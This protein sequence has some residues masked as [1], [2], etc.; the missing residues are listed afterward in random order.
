MTRHEADGLLER[1][2]REAGFDDFGWHSLR[3]TFASH[4][5]MRGVQLKAVQELL[6]HATIDMRMRHTHLSPNVRV[7]AVEVLD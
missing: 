4:L 5:V 3:H 1:V 7:S 2:Q 6:E